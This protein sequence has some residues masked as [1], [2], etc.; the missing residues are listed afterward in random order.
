[1]LFKY[2]NDLWWNYFPG[3]Y[4]IIDCPPN[5]RLE[6]YKQELEKII[7]IKGWDWDW[8]I[9]ELYRLKIKIRK[10]KTHYISYFLMRWT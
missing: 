7:G 6:T 9:F 1:M 10:G 5:I 8:E 2:L 3:K 4:I